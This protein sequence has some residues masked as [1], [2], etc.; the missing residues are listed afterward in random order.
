MQTFDLIC[1]K[2]TSAF[3]LKDI[4]QVINKAGFI[5]FQHSNVTHLSGLMKIETC[6]EEWCID[7]QTSWQYEI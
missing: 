4:Y 7:A 2:K 1:W 6:K 3:W 5:P